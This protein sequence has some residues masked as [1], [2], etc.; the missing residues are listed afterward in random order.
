MLLPTVNTNEIHRIS[1]TEDFCVKNIAFGDDVKGDARTVVKVHYFAEVDSEDEEAA[2]KAN[3]D[4]EVQKE[5]VLCSLI[6][7]KVRSIRCT[8]CSTDLL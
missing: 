2:D 7:G 8:N 6:P 1:V 3:E 5:Y 4:G